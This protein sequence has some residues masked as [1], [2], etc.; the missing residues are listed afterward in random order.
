LDL[1]EIESVLKILKKAKK[2]RVVFMFQVIDALENLERDF[3]KKF[4]SDILK[5]CEW[6][7]LSLPTE[8]LGGR[9]KFIIQRKWLLDFL[10]EN[11]VVKM[12]FILNG[13]RII[14]FHK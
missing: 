8:S 7:V 14:C 5:E 1:F 4:I 12:D 9:K 13:E 3:S 6:I 2:S 10:E 11:F